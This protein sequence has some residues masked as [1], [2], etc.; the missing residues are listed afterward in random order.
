MGLFDWLKQKK[1]KP[2]NIKYAFTQTGTIPIF[3]SSNDNILDDD[4]VVQCIGAIAREMK[5]L[6]PKHV[7]ANE[8]TK[9]VVNDSINLVFILKR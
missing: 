8:E 3:S 4:T 7:R 2:Q 6:N 5:K 1:P 9:V